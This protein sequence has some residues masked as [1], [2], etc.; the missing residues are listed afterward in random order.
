MGPYV[1]AEYLSFTSS[2][3]IL[4]GYSLDLSIIGLPVFTRFSASILADSIIIV[5]GLGPPI[6]S[7]IKFSDFWYI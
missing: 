6:F 4:T 3:N 2:H 1:N 7:K 5:Q